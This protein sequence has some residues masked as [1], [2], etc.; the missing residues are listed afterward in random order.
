MAQSYPTSHSGEH[1]A[2]LL[3]DHFF[4]DHTKP[5]VLLEAFWSH[6]GVPHQGWARPPPAEESR[7]AQPWAPSCC[8]AGLLGASRPQHELTR[9]LLCVPIQGGARGIP[10]STDIPLPS[11]CHAVRSLGL[12]PYPRHSTDRQQAAQE[13]R[14]HPANIG[15]LGLLTALLRA[16]GAQRPP[17]STRPAKPPPPEREPGSIL[18]VGHNSSRGVLPGPTRY[19]RSGP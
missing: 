17:H 18:P 4:T 16:C 15:L 13:G 6:L 7:G 8:P 9:G 10:S 2:S 11:S 1:K 5:E 19:E 14:H 12:S 3:Q